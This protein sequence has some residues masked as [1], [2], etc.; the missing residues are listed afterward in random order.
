M[1]ERRTK[2]KRD[3][4]ATRQ[5][6]VEAGAV[7]FSERGYDGVSTE[8]VADR[9]GVNKALISYHFGGKRG[10]Y[11]AVLASAF[12]AMAERL[13]AAEARGGDAR[14]LLHGFLASFEELR[15][16]RPDFPTLFMRE[17]LSSGLE[18]AVLPH[19][20]EII[21]T[22]RRFVE[23]G[24]REGVF[25]P[26]DPLLVHFALVGSVA[27][28]LA[29]EPARQRAVAEQRMP[30]RM[31]DLPSFLQYVEDLT[32]RGL[33]PESPAPRRKGARR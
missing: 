32:M 12:R 33:A 7:L 6:L 9:A 13:R 11:T 2:E 30:I 24:V 28:F 16:A 22:V 21:L 5:A 17:V 14:E 8:D 25:R 3:P 26:V 29:T 15:R 23:R 10:L 27:F 1:R 20:L 18:P 31:P 4:E 19:L